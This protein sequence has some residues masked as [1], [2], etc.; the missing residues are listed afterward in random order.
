M[1]ITDPFSSNQFFIVSQTFYPIMEQHQSSKD[2]IYSP[3]DCND[4]FQY[5]T[6][7]ND[8]TSE[9]KD[10]FESVLNRTPYEFQK[11]VRHALAAMSHPNHPLSPSSILLVR[12]TGGGKSSVYVSHSIVCA[13]FSLNIV[14]LLSLGVDQKVKV[15]EYRSD[16]VSGIINAIHLDDYRDAQQQK[17]LVQDLMKIKDDTKQTFF[18]FASPQ[19]IVNSD[20]YRKLIDYIIATKLLRLVTVDELHLYAAFGLS[21]RDEF[22]QLTEHLFVKLRVNS[23]D[24]SNIRSHK[25]RKLNIAKK[26]RVPILWMT[27]TALKSIIQELEQMTRIQI[28]H[29]PR[30]IFWPPAL[31]MYQPRVNLDVVYSSTP[32][33]KFKDRIIGVLQED[34]Q[35][36]FI[37]YTNNLYTL[38][39]NIKNMLLAFD[40][41]PNI[42]ADLVPLSGDFVK[43]QKMWHILQFCKDNESNEPTLETCAEAD[44]PFNPQLLMATSGSANAGID[45]K[46]IQG[47]GRGEFPPSIRDLMQELGRAGRW[48]YSEKDGCWYLVSLSLESFCSLLRRTFRAKESGATSE[49]YYN[50]LIKDM[51]EVLSILVIPTQCLHWSAA[52]ILENPYCPT[53]N[54]NSVQQACRDKCSFCRGEFKET[55]PPISRSGLTRVLLDIFINKRHRNTILT[56]DDTLVDAIRNYC[57]DQGK[58]AARSLIFQ[59][60]G[61]ASNLQP[62]AVKKVIFQC[63]A[64][65][66][67]GFECESRNVAA[68]GTNDKDRRKVDIHAKLNQDP[69]TKELTLNLDSP[70]ALIATK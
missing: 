4:N 36:K 29:D 42:M 8:V 13:G 58:K 45:C 44:R 26:T 20:H 5:K 68:D 31:E 33:T 62:V 43:E 55:Y 63:I 69:V 32:I 3:V 47:V 6:F 39:Q 46:F 28:S 25:K 41:N 56:I 34:R 40:S 67:I 70:W 9:T 17:N 2:N 15:Q 35:K 49:S 12:P 65:G 30:C 27:A 16:E 23:Y 1:V 37:W 11:N 51:Y 22:V 61:K 48:A 59:S 21:F 10:V 60:R 38:E 14:P 64:A 19:A 50:S 66:F 54:L 7:F 52:V 18:L 53:V 24:A 57:D